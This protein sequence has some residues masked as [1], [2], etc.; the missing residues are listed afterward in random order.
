MLIKGIIFLLVCLLF[1]SRLI[2]KYSEF[3]ETNNVDL[4][5]ITWEGYFGGLVLVGI[6]VITIVLLV[7][8]I[9][10][11]HQYFSSPSDEGN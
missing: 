1:I 4:F 3:R 6:A 7:M 2:P 8:G 11:I 9:Q 10:N 5:G